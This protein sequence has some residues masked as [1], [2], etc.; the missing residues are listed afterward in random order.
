[1]I[2][3]RAERSVKER[4]AK[5]K[6]AALPVRTVNPGETI[7]CIICLEDATHPA[8]SCVSG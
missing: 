2:R 4:K 8:V 1:M 3:E 6:I 7:E 5:Q